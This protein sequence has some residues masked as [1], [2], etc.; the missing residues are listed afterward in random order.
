MELL[1]DEVGFIVLYLVNVEMEE[2]V[3]N[4]YELIKL[5]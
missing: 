5:M 4:I 2:E 1:M 3:G